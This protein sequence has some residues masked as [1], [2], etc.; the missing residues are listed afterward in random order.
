MLIHHLTNHKMSNLEKDLLLLTCVHGDESYANVAVERLQ[1][2]LGD[3]FDWII[4][5]PKA[6]AL[7]QRFIDKDMNRVA[8]GRKGDPCYE[9]SRVAE[10]V[11]S[12]R[13]YPYVID[14][15]GTTADSGIFTI[16]AGPNNLKRFAL[17]EALP[18]D[19]IVCWTDVAE[20]ATG[21]GPI[22][23]KIPCGVAIEAGPKDDPAI[24]ETLYGKLSELIRSGIAECLKRS[25]PDKK[26]IYR[27]FGFVPE[28]DSG[29][30][31][32]FRDFELTEFKGESFY[33][34]LAGQYPGVACYKME[35]IDLFDLFAK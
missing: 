13:R 22:M 20:K 27:V 35:K 31:V 33:P 10:V 16:V 28:P 24:G 18:I 17:A 4:A 5:N 25:N 9:I 7:N 12:A 1:K 14:I 34:L 19:R 11:E 21:V 2:E 26:E 29:S 6:L 8:P 3:C 23:T 15:H 32:I 30:D